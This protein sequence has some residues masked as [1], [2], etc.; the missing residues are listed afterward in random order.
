[1]PT[2]HLLFVLC[3]YRVIYDLANLP[4]QKHNV[5]IT[6]VTLARGW[7][8]AGRGTRHTLDNRKSSEF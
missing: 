1:M 2:A 3:Q 4:D 8:Y 5:E 7:N 6:L